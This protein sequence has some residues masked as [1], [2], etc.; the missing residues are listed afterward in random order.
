MGHG[1]GQE[2]ENPCLLVL[3]SVAEATTQKSEHGSVL[4]TAIT[5]KQQSKRG[6]TSKRRRKK[7]IGA[8]S[9]GVSNLMHYSLH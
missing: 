7:N 6:A 1:M 8:K 5:S 2:K 3:E 9:V 4:N